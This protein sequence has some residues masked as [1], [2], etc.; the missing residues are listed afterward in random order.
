MMKTIYSFCVSGILRHKITLMLM[1]STLFGS[2]EIFASH[3]AGADL[4]YQSL[5]NNQYQ[6][7]YTLYRDCDGISAPTTKSI[8]Y[9]SVSCNIPSQSV[10]LNQV[11]GTGYEITSNCSSA[12]STCNGGSA[13]GIQKYEYTAVVTLPQACVDWFFSAGEC[14]RNNT[15]TTLDNP[16]SNDLFIDAYLNNTNVNNSSPTFTNVPIAF[17]CIGQDN[18]FNHGVIDAEGDSLVYSFVPPRDAVN[19]PIAYAPGFST[20]NPLTSTSGN[21]VSI[22]P[23][24]GDIFMNPAAVEVAVIAVLIREY[25]NG[26]LIGTVMRDI[27]IYTTTCSNALPQGTGVDGTQIFATSSCGGQ[28]CFDV[29]GSDPDPNDS[30]TMTWNQA[31]P[32]ATFTVSGPFNA[33]VG[34]FCWTP[35]PGDARSAPYTFTVSVRDNACPSN[36]V[37]TYSYSITVSNMDMTLVHSTSVQCPGA[38][39]GTA[40]VTPTG[41]DPFSYVWTGPNGLE[42][43]TPSISHLYAGNYTLNVT[44]ATGCMGTRTFSILEP[45]ALNLTVTGIDAGCNSQFGSATAVVSGGTGPTYTYLWDDP[46]AQTSATADDLLPGTYNVLVK[47]A[48][49]CPVSGSVTIAGT[50]PISATISSRPATCVANDGSAT[51]VVTGGSGNITYTWTPNVSTTAS[52]TGLITGQ[53]DC[54]VTD[55]TSGCTISLSTI[56]ANSAGI[57]ATIVASSDA[58][59][60]SSEDG[61]AT[62][63]ATG[64]TMPYT[65]LWPNGDTTASVNNLAPGTYLVMVEDYLGCRAYASVT[66]GFVN[67][68]PSV[69]LG[70]DTTVCIGATLVLDAG[71]GATSYLWS[72]NSTG[73]TLTVSTAGTYSVLVT[74]SFGC[75]NFDAIAVNFIQCQTF[76]TNNGDRYNN[77]H[78]FTVSPNPFRDQFTVNIAKIKDT[79]VRILVYDVL[80]NQL[81]SSNEK[82]QT[83]YHKTL[84][85][86]KYSA[87][88]YLMKVEYNNEI[89]T[90]RLVKE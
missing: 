60:Q 6:I 39:T 13:T 90:I 81:Y 44:D 10:T 30:L 61:S 62:V 87:G 79:N 21:T 49:N 72:D 3:A 73:Q 14:C 37:T 84:D 5:G 2:Q 64:G 83:G 25:R 41:V 77:W 28:I 69:N 38:H 76:Q 51:V 33:P 1:I 57:T 22:D 70:N 63:S 26:E 15:I 85:L 78:A 54:L 17:M 66:I 36:G 8:Q 47:D 20:A 4:T 19:T 56:V 23:V 82:S 67:P 55:V 65:Y 88:I 50:T 45:P 12:V 43:F 52:A 59:C 71:A 31:I 16:A 32:G 9:G 7:T 27:Q 29:Y 58:T 53:Y 35:D 40:S 34:R 86:G 80:G 11:P 24:T 89:Q 74:N 75:E 46:D 68:S 42:L 48:N 18:F